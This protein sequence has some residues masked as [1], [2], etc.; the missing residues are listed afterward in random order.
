[1][2][3]R[4]AAL[5]NRRRGTPVTV[6]IGGAQIMDAVTVRSAG[7]VGAGGTHQVEKVVGEEATPNLVGGFAQ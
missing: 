2:T 7:Q 5:R 3:Y 4:D 6:V 1:M